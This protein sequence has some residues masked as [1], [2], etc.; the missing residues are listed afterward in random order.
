MWGALFEL[1]AKGGQPSAVVCHNAAFARRCCRCVA[2][3]TQN[4]TIKLGVWRRPSNRQNVCAAA[5]VVVVV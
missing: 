4:G 3:A 1:A 2:S 5:A